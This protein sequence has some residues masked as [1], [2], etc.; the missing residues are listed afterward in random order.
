M[1]LG[2]RLTDCSLGEIGQHFGGRDHSTV[3]HSIEKIRQCV[4]QDVQLQS[5]IEAMESR[6]RQV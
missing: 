4:E 5:S 6:L 2:R 1:Y 3:L